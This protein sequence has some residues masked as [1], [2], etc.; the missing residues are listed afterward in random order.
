M[1]WGS[2]DVRLG[3]DV[4]GGNISEVVDPFVG[5]LGIPSLQV[6]D[7]WVDELDASLWAWFHLFERCKAT[8]EVIV[9]QVGRG[10][11]SSS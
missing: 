3:L 9:I 7:R 4:L 8:D 6:S 1:G 11:V 5:V 2:I 10:A